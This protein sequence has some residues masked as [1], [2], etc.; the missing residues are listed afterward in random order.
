MSVLLDG[1][2]HH[3]RYSFGHLLPL[4]FFGQELLP[5][6]IRQAVVFEFAVSVGSRLPFGTY[7]SSLLQTMQRGVERA[8]LH[9]QEFICSPLN[10]L[11]DLVTVSGSIE[12]RPQ[13]EHVKRSLEEPDPLLRLLRHRRYSTLN[14][15]TIVDTRLSI[16]GRIRVWILEWR[17]HANPHWITSRFDKSLRI[18]GGVSI[19]SDHL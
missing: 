1:G 4:R 18:L 8:V 17:L 12:K 5:A 2:P 9:L 7:P 13:D 3:A 6:F 16:N 14:L 15:A 11:P 19:V 10:V